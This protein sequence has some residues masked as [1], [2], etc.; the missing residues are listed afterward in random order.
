MRIF[1]AVA[2]VLSLYFP[3]ALHLNE[4]SR[5]DPASLRGPF[6]RYANS[7]AYF[8]YPII[9]GAIPDDEEHRASSTAVLLEND[10]PL[11]P[12][13]SP[14]G[15]I[16]AIGQG[17]YSLWRKGGTTLVFSTSDNSDPNTNGRVYRLLDMNARDP[18][19]AQRR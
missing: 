1:S 8:A 14:H 12:A 7:N 3:V 9:P 10:K 18:F 2:A 19:E 15:E 6:D 16:T 5:I 4:G 13:H 17:R 11:G